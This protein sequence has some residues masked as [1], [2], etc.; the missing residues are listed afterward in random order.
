MQWPIFIKYLLCTKYITCII[1]EQCSTL[2]ITDNFGS[3]WLIWRLFSPELLAFSLVA[4]INLVHSCQQLENEKTLAKLPKKSKEDSRVRGSENTLR[5]SASQK[6][7]K[8]APHISIKSL[9]NKNANGQ[10]QFTGEHRLEK[11][12]KAATW[13]RLLLRETKVSPAEFVHLK[14]VI[15]GHVYIKTI[16]NL[17]SRLYLPMCARV[18]VECACLCMCI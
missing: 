17:L 8:H 4:H 1:F 15:Q 14:V 3:W 6:W 7:Q 5:D 11:F 18:Y 16:L 2:V 13:S 10:H 12:H 9:L